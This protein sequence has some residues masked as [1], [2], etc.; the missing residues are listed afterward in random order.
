MPT[1]DDLQQQIANRQHAKRLLGAMGEVYN[2]G[3]SIRAKL[4]LYIA[5]TNPDFN[6]VMDSVFT[7]AERTELNQMLSP[8]ANLIDDWEANHFSFLF[9]DPE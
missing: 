7:S 4:D 5:G 1:Y 6:A 9:P 2:L 3:K 8:L